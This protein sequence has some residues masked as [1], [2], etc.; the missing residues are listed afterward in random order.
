MRDI[1][2]IFA[3]IALLGALTAGAII[4]APKHDPAKPCTTI[5]SVIKVACR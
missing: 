5:G 2:A 3:A 4:I 1:L